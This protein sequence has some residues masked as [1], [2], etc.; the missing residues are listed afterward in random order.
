[1]PR[2]RLGVAVLVP[3]RVAGEVDGLRRACGDPSFGRVPPHLT[4]VPPVN[5]RV[6]RLGDA[7]AVLR[8]AAAR[9]DGPLELTVGPP[10][11]FWP[12]TPVLYLAVGGEPAQL[13][14]LHALR[15]AVFAEPLARRLTWPFFPHVTLADGL[16][17][18]RLAAAVE[19]LAGFSVPVVLD[20]VHLMEEARDGSGTRV[21][22]PLADAPL[23]PPAVVAR[24][25]LALELTAS[26]LVD[27]EAAAATGVSQPEPGDGGVP[28]AVTGRRRDGVAGVAAGWTRDAV[29]HL[30][31]VAVV[32][33]VRRQGVG[34]HLV[35]AFLAAAAGR[36][37]GALDGSAAVAAGGDGV[38]ALLGTVGG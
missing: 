14:A 26:L 13:A 24:G 20:R 35:T 5:V 33:D 2:R 12:D 23:G 25:G 36:G 3:P 6:E 9:S 37:A 17:P 19:A 18:E 32:P 11:T 21:W 16:A 27:P 4:L 38:S 10:A 28:L 7:L 15:D 34:R 8:A 29:A 30:T 1:V 22:R 31:A